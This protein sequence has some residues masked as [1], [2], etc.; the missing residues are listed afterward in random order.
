MQ[1]SSAPE[2][3]VP[4]PD[5]TVMRLHSGLQGPFCAATVA[6]V[7]LPVDSDT[8]LEVSYDSASDAR[9]VHGLSV[10]V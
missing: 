3:G 1:I 9:Q 2:D 10:G 5:R 7:K 4:V 8:L 6:V